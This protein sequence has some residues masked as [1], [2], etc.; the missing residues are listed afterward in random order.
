[1]NTY[2]LM[3][4][5]SHPAHFQSFMAKHISQQSSSSKA[6]VS[7]FC[8]CVVAPNFLVATKLSMM[9]FLEKALPSLTLSASVTVSSN[10]Q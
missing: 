1:M 7:F 5:T 9:L 2:F 6:L 4:S 10:L 3:F 8:V